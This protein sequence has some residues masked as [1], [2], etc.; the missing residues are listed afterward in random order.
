MPLLW[1]RRV[2]ATNGGGISA[3]RETTPTSAEF[4]PSSFSG[5]RGVRRL[6]RHVKLRNDYV[7]AAAEEHIAVV[8]DDELS[9]GSALRMPACA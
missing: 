7:P 4:S 2:T 3:S 6:F 9:L 1:Y 5:A 8:A